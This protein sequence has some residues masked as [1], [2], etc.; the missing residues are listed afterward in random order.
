MRTKNERTS[1]T[2]AIVMY[3][4][5][6]TAGSMVPSPTFMYATTGSLGDAHSAIVATISNP[7]ITEMVSTPA[8][9]LEHTSST[10]SVTAMTAQPF[11]RPFL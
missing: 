7:A 9:S 10:P 8:A 3:S 1:D 11:T 2:S 4:P 5:L 6:N